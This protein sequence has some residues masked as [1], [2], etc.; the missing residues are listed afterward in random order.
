MPAAQPT[1]LDISGNQLLGGLTDHDKNKLRPHLEQVSLSQGEVLSRAG[2]A[3]KYAYFPQDAVLSLL[4]FMEQGVTVEVGLIGHEG[5]VG[6]H[7][8]MGA[9]TWSNGADVQVS[10]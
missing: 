2:E 8:V 3:I 10:G 9:K 7:A 6:F 5:L 1:T 4:S